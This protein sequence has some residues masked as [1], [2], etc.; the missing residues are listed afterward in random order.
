[1][2]VSAQLLSDITGPLR[3]ASAAETANEATIIWQRL[4]C[5]FV[6]LIGP[7]SVQMIVGRSLDACQ[8]HY[9]WL[10]RGSDPA[11]CAPPYDGLR[12]AFKS[13]DRDAV[14]AATTAM[15]ATYANQLDTLIGARLAE[16]FLRATF[17]AP[18]DATDTRSKSE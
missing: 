16:Q 12:A 17:P 14:L 3:A 8:D 13:A 4:A 15:L 5:K 11:L 2:P 7:S 9:P 10:G 18:A 6:P 1:M